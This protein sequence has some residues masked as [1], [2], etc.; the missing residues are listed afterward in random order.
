MRYTLIFILLVLTS[1]GFSQDVSNSTNSKKLFFISPTDGELVKNPVRI[2]FGING[3]NIV[4][5]GVDEPMSGHHHLLINLD[6]LPSMN[7]PIPADKNHLHFGKGQTETI[8]ELPKGKH[9]LQL[10]LGNHI[11]IPHEK[12]LMSEKIEITV[13]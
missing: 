8:M 7:M 9:T 12:P 3:M 1:H 5:A 13:E 4:P 11:H 10:L 6:K 2:K